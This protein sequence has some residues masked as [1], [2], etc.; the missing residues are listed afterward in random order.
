MK[1]LSDDEEENQEVKKVSKIVDYDK[2]HWW[3]DPIGQLAIGFKAR[4]PT[5]VE[6]EMGPGLTIYFR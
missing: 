4:E 1:S 2:Y 3:R 6:I 5:E